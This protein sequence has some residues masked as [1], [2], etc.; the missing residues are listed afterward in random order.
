MQLLACSVACLPYLHSAVFL[1]RCFFVYHS[2]KNWCLECWRL[3]GEENWST[4][5][6]TSQSKRARTNN[7][8]NQQ[9]YMYG[10]TSRTCTLAILVGRELS[11]TTTLSF[12]SL[13]HNC[14]R[15]QESAAYSWSAALFYCIAK[16]FLNLSTFLGCS[17]C[18]D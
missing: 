12:L 9:V 15:Q 4:Q 17:C 18:T 6:K 14:R 3:R 1:L 10:T 16:F 5:I 7:R 2:G 11:H 8:F 13:P